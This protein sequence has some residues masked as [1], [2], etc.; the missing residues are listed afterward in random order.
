MAESTEKQAGADAKPNGANEDEIPKKDET[1]LNSKEGTQ[2]GRSGFDAPRPIR[3][4]GPP[5]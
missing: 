2:A 1:I 4:P 3:G 5:V